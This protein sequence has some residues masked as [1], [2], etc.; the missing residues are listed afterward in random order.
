MTALDAVPW[1]PAFRSMLLGFA[2]CGAAVALLALWSGAVWAWPLIGVGAVMALAT[3]AV[4]WKLGQR[5]MLA[6]D[7]GRLVCRLEAS[8]PG[9]SANLLN[10]AMFDLASIETVEREIHPWPGAGGERHYY[11]L[12]LADGSVRK[13]VPRPADPPTRAAAAAFFE[14][15]FPGRVRETRVG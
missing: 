11:R 6:V 14:R 10:E 12:L 1:P 2:C 8:R 4:W 13:L 5:P 15:H 7:Q 9:K 3:G